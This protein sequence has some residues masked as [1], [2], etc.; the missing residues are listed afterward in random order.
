MGHG[1][2]NQSVLDDLL[3]WEVISKPVHKSLC[4]LIRHD[5]IDYIEGSCGKHKSFTPFCIRFVSGRLEC[6]PTG[7]KAYAKTFSAAPATQLP[8]FTNPNQGGEQQC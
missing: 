6:R 4:V 7:I 3:A 2:Y 8:L 5:A 1:I